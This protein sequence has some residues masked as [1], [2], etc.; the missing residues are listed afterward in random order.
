MA[1]PLALRALELWSRFPELRLGGSTA[2]ALPPPD[3]D[4][5]P[6]VLVFVRDRKR[7]AAAR[8][9]L[10]RLI[11]LDDGWQLVVA[12]GFGLDLPEAA[13][14]IVS[15]GRSATRMRKLLA[16]LK[17]IAI[18][19]IGD[20]FMPVLTAGARELGIPLIAIDIDS[21]PRGWRLWRLMRGSATE[22]LRTYDRLLTPDG[23]TYRRMR[24]MG[25][26]ES[27]VEKTGPLAALIK[28]P[29]YR[30][31][32]R[33]SIKQ[34]LGARPVWCAVDVPDDEIEMVMQALDRAVR[35]AH[36]LLLV[37]M[38][39][40]PDR[41][42]AVL[43]AVKAAGHEPLVRSEGDDPDPETSVYI[44]DI[45]EEHGLW[46]SLS[47]VT[48]L[49]GTIGNQG[50]A[51]SP[52]EPAT[53]GSA[54]VHGPNYGAHGESFLHLTD[55]GASRQITN[56]GELGDAVESLSVPDVQAALAARAWQLATSAADVGER[57]HALIRRFE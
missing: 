55:A 33:L 44:A 8:P 49:G 6:A 22:I 11:D 48:Y 13:A 43:A 34:G 1:Y 12:G 25:A 19:V 29:R 41:L 7:I 37:I 32:E 36:R 20:P 56:W 21:P 54:V 42:E 35:R 16:T 47:G 23:L 40:N 51:R 38:P 45:W 10:E 31:E 4:D 46:F 30:P 15:P 27:R 50:A 57:L 2:L 3:A 53:L 5:R 39:R 17:P 52:M 24:R 18:V 14:R 9:V 28:P 26:G